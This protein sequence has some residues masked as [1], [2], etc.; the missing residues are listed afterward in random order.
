MLRILVIEDEVLISLL[1]QGMLRELGHEVAGVAHHE[2]EALALIESSRTRFDAATVDIS[3]DGEPCSGAVAA[4]HRRGIP[5]I[6][7]TGF[8]DQDL[9][10][11][12][13]GCPVPGKPFTADELGKVLDILSA[14]A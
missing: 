10:E 12:V 5:F 6:V 11:Y 1:M 13:R 7:V 4:L 8:L 3:L 9:P 14:S 2:D